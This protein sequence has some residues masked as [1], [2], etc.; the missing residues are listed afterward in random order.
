M[1]NRR[2]ALYYAVYSR[3]LLLRSL[4]VTAVIIRN[5]HSLIVD[6]K[7]IY[8]LNTTTLHV[9][10]DLECSNSVT[11]DDMDHADLVLGDD[12]DAVLE[13]VEKELGECTT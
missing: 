4:L 13:E 6:V 10:D 8:L 9:T 5:R 7:A 3:I 12:L 1:R 11:D 2:C